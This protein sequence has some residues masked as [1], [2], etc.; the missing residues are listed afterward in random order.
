MTLENIKEFLLKCT[1]GKERIERACSN[2]FVFANGE[3]FREPIYVQALEELLRE[4]HIVQIPTPGQFR[5]T[6]S[7]RRATDD[8]LSYFHHTVWPVAAS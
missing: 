5:T 4:R 1:E 6:V 8:E 2:R 3:E 7:Y